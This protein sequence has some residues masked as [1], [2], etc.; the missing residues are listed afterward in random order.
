MPT[1]LPADDA[2]SE[3]SFALIMV[4]YLVLYSGLNS[5]LQK[6]IEDFKE[7]MMKSRETAEKEGNDLTL[8]TFRLTKELWN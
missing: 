7:Q 2:V 8:S 3:D 6:D 4:R 5:F 1:P